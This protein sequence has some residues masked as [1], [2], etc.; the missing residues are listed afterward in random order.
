MDFS[1]YNM[2]STLGLIS[3]LNVLY[4]KPRTIWVF[5]TE[6]KISPLRIIHFILRTL[7]NEKNPSICFR[8][9]EDVSLSKSI[10]VTKLL[11]DDFRISM[12]TNG[13]DASWINGNNKQHNRIIYNILKEIILDSTQHEKKW[14]CESET[15]AEVYRCKIH[16]ELDNISHNFSWYGRNI[17][18]HE[19]I[20]F[21]C[22]IYPIT[23]S[24]KHLDNR[25]Q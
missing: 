15:P 9:H 17:S 8:Y 2:H 1:F 22:D 14:C 24:P 11:V 10:D 19:L 20:K 3:I 4:E 16:S 12:E 13:G 5:P 23:S 25:T 6:S 18:I 21:G 7:N